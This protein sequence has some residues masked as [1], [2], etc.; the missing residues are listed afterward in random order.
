MK[1][2]GNNAEIFRGTGLYL[3]LLKSVFIISV[4]QLWNSAG[5]IIILKQY[6]AKILAI[7]EAHCASEIWEGKKFQMYLLN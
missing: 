6:I 5:A 4:A 7:W 3:C 1:G 2:P